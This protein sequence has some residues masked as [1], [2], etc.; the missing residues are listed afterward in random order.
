VNAHDYAE[1]LCRLRAWSSHSPRQDPITPR[2]QFL[3][4][5]LKSQGIDYEIDSFPVAQR[6]HANYVNVCVRFGAKSAPEETAVVCAHH[7]VSNPDSDNCQDNTASVAHLLALCL[8]LK[9]R[10]PQR[11][12]VLVAF[13]D[14]EEIVDPPHSGAGRLAQRCLRGD[15]GTATHVLNL[16]LTANGKNIWYENGQRDSSPL[17]RLLTRQLSTIFKASTPYNDAVAFRRYGLDSVCLGP[18]DD[19]NFAQLRRT[20]F[21]NTWGLCHSQQDSFARSARREDMEAFTQWIEEL[22]NVPLSAAER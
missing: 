20:G 10:P 13:L 18:L 1:K 19:E 7:D 17:A 3:L 14:A 8:K 15:Y 5:S 2:V 22:I 11:Q 12:R 4:D 9:A 16:E 6:A 21:C